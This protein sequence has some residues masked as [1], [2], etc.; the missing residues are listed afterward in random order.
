[1]ARSKSKLV[2][3]WVEPHIE[4]IVENRVLVVLGVSKSEYVR[5]LVIGDLNNRGLLQA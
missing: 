2:G 5:Q 1:M 4:S 3:G